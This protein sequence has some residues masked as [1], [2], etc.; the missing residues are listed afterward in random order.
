M[1]NVPPPHVYVNNSLG[2]QHGSLYGYRLGG[3]HML[4][5]V[6]DRIGPRLA[7]AYGID[8]L[9]RDA[10]LMVEPREWRP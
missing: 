9:G 1:K 8:Q 10:G 4:R 7:A 3:A 5:I 6:I 2:N